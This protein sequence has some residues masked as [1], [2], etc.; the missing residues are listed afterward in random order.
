M[1]NRSLDRLRHG[2]L[3]PPERGRRYELGQ[4]GL[5]IDAPEPR[6]ALTS[7]G[8]QIA[9]TVLGSGPI[10]LIQ[11]SSFTSHCE[12]W[13]EHPWSRRWQ[14]RLASFTRLICFDKRGSGLSDRISGAPTL[15]ERM[16]DVRAVM[17]AVGTERAALVGY[18][19]GGPMSVLFAATYPERVSALVLWGATA[20]FTRKDDYPWGPAP[21]ANEAI[22]LAIE[23][24]WGT[25][26][27]N[28]VVAPG[29]VLDETFQHWMARLE[30]NTATPKD[31]A[32]L[33][34][35]NAGIDVR[36][37]LPAVS[38]PTLVLHRS[39]DPAIPV[40][41][42]RY[43]ADHIPGARFV[44]FAGDSH[45]NFVGDFE[46]IIDEIEEFLTGDR[47][48]REPDRVLATVV[49]TDIVDSTGHA[50]TFG[51]RQWRQV[52]DELDHETAREVSAARGR[53]VKFTGDGHLAV[54]DGPARAI[55]CAESLCRA[56]RQRGIELRV[57]IHTGEVETRG[58]DV[59]GVA[60][61]LAQLV[62]DLAEAGEVLVSRTVTDLVAGSGIE[63]EDRGEHELK[64]VPGNWG[65][66]AVREAPVR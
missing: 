18:W 28:A 64:G 1:P 20:T 39:A 49:F 3:T 65:L 16:D 34:R 21:Q 37:V 36:S 5:M 48:V 31:A 29:L 63:F 32:A 42:G 44:E 52:L 2:D 60:V 40:E 6:Y 25:G 56:S 22:V 23:Q 12:L 53:L 62:C 66:F 24:W 10:D 50:I 17:D 4:T 59:S 47:H 54:F 15:E 51:D 33:F 55:R 43:V 11:V 8:L 30:R 46:G 26:I 38:V 61:H 45:L 27:S 9:Y 7:D 14:E 57:G 19:E 13:W 41:A 35:L 58:E